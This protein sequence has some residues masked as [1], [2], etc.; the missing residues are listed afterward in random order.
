[1]RVHCLQE[2]ALAYYCCCMPTPASS[3]PAITESQTDSSILFDLL[4][5]SNT[6]SSLS[7]S[8]ATMHISART[9][10]MMP[11]PRAK[12]APTKFTGKY[13]DV[14]HFLK[15]Y[16]NLCA[17]YNVEEDTEKCER[18]LDYCSHKVIQLIEALKS[19]TE[20]NWANLEADLLRYYDAD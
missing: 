16:N 5:S 4:S 11:S 6:P 9:P 15:R 2:P 17:T 18:I 3:I 20:K 14:K 19:Y 7:S 1:V 13:E 8:S 10:A 12:E